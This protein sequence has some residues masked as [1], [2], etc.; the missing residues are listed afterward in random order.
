MHIFCLL[1]KRLFERVKSALCPKHPK[2]R[3]PDVRGYNE[4]VRVQCHRFLCHFLQTH[5]HPRPTICSKFGNWGNE[6]R[7]FL[8]HL[9]T[10]QHH[11]RVHSSFLASRFF[12]DVVYFY[13]R[14]ERNAVMNKKTALCPRCLLL[15]FLK[16]FRVRHISCANKRNSFSLGRL[17]HMRNIH[18][19][20]AAARIF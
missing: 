17:S 8:R 6:R 19:G 12:E 5:S 7:E 10:R 4:Y 9:Q 18:L 14:N 2:P 3:S 16:I 11:Q 20:R 15:Y 1:S 13:R